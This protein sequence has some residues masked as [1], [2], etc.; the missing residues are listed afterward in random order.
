MFE[1]IKNVLH[2]S[3]ISLISV[4]SDPEKFRVFL[5]SHYDDQKENEKS[6]IEF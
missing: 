3:N 2:S 1:W 4:P 5:D 6:I